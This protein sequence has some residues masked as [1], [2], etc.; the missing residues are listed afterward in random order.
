ME[1]MIS[2]PNPEITGSHYISNGGTKIGPYLPRPKFTNIY[3]YIHD[4]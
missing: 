2:V 3:L 1:L 4:Y